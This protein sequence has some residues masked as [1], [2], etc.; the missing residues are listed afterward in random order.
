MVTT[1]ERLSRVE[2]AYEQVDRR[3]GDI[4]GEM[5]GLRS[6]LNG[7]IDET[8]RAIEGL[9]TELGGRIDETNR[10]IGGLRTEIGNRMNIMETRLTAIFIG[11]MAVGGGIFAALIGVIVTLWLTV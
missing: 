10:A 7:R 11:M 1:E 8:N 4:R 6:D 5:R 2:G 9:R 3:L